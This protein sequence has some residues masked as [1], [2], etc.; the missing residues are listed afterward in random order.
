MKRNYL[1]LSRQTQDYIEVA[2]IDG[3]LTQEEIEFI[4]RKAAEFGDDP[5]E[6]EMVLTSILFQSNQENNEFEFIEVEPK[7]G[8]VESYFRA[9]RKYTNFNGRAS[10]AEFWFFIVFNYILLFTLSLFLGFQ[11][12]NFIKNENNALLIGL[13]GLLY[14]IALLPPFI[15]LCIRRVH[16]LNLAGWH[17][18]IPAYNIYL[19]LKK[20]H[21]GDNFFG[22]DPYQTTKIKVAPNNA[23]LDRLTNN[24]IETIGATMF[25]IGATSHEAI[26]LGIIDFQQLDNL[27]KWLWL[28]GGVLIV[29]PKIIRYIT[30]KK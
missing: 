21:T 2:T 23:L 15:C 9:I 3:K 17:A 14:P 28:L 19:F 29:I 18:F 25:G 12:E 1:N 27:N 13:V 7:Y 20:G 30:T 5:V 16:D 24:K 26:E 11:D 4:K 8:L 10:R 6:V 22:A